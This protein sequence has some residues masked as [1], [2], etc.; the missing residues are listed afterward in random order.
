VE[1]GE[2]GR[3]ITVDHRHRTEQE[4]GAAN[5]E[6][7]KRIKGLRRRV[8]VVAVAGVRRSNNVNKRLLS[9]NGN[10]RLLSNGGVAEGVRRSNNVN[11][12]LLSNNG[13]KRLLSKGRAVRREADEVAGSSRTSKG[14]SRVAEGHHNSKGRAAPRGDLGAD[15]EL[16]CK[17]SSSKE[18]GVAEAE[19][20]RGKARLHSSAKALPHRG[21]SKCN[22]EEVTNR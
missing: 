17:I 13:N 19:A 9:N 21:N 3:K 18:G 10:K 6:G 12:R 14:S 11:K 20:A 15:A 8:G 2:L 1:A 7:H 4:E 5:V 16:P 22:N